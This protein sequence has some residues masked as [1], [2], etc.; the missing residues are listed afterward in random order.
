VSL[1]TGTVTSSVAIHWHCNSSVAIHCYCNW[2]IVWCLLCQ[3]TVNSTVP[4]SS[5]TGVTIATLFGVYSAM[6]SGVYSATLS[7]TGPVSGV[8]TVQCL[9][10]TATVSGTECHHTVIDR[11]LASGYCQAVRRHLLN[12]DILGG[13]LTLTGLNRCSVSVSEL[14]LSWSLLTNSTSS[15]DLSPCHLGY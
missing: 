10:F 5:V 13:L 9:H 14:S 12:A 8:C 2:C 15:M 6:V 3:G 4:V 1:Y 7:V 11:K